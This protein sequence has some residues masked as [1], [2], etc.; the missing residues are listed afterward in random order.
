MI[1]ILL[2]IFCQSLLEVNAS[3]QQLLESN[4]RELQCTEGNTEVERWKTLVV[5][6]VNEFAKCGEAMFGLLRV[7]KSENEFV[8]IQVH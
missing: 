8:S 3:F 1:P 4:E 5:H 2:T 6:L 7:I